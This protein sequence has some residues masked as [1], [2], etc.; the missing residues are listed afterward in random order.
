MR[1]AIVSHPQ[2]FAAFSSSNRAAL[3][4]F[5]E[6]KDMQILSDFDALIHLGDDACLQDYLHFPIPIFISSVIHTLEEQGHGQQV[7]RFNGWEGFYQKQIWEISGPLSE[8]HINVLNLLGKSY[9]QVPDICGFIS[10][11][12][13]SMIINEAFFALESGVS[14]EKEIDTAMRLGTNYPMGPFEWAD[15][16]GREKWYSLLL[17]L[18]AS[19]SRYAPCSL[20]QTKMN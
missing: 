5:H 19:D 6:L 3:V 20:L 17:K 18:S 11:R 1:I 16:I 13:I 14:S 15:L 4:H 9:N 10:C 12:V 2:Q 8:Q 7:V